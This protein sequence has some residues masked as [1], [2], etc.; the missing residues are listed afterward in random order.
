M[1]DNA[2]RSGTLRWSVVEYH[3]L[4]GLEEE[5]DI[6]EAANDAFSKRSKKLYQKHAHET[7]FMFM[8]HALQ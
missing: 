4:R 7:C 8:F 5:L 2:R 6:L 1:A 3:G